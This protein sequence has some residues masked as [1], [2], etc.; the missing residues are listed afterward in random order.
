[1]DL[2]SHLNMEMKTLTT[3]IKLFCTKKINAINTVIWY[4]AVL[5]Y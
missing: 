1:M 2:S 3:F 4:L 5:V